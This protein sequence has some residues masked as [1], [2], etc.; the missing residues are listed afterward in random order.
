VVSEKDPEGVGNWL[1]KGDFSDD[2]EDSLRELTDLNEVVSALEDL[3][4]FFEKSPI[5]ATC[6]KVIRIYPQV[7]AIGCVGGSPLGS[8]QL[9]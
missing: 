9:L 7:I 3:D 6:F 8:K 2:A 4:D 1:N 5:F